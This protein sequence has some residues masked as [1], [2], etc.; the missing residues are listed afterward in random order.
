MPT[1]KKWIRASLLTLVAILVVLEIV[2]LR[3]S[4]IEEE[5]TAPKKIDP[6]ALFQDH[7]PTVVPGVPKNRIPEYSVENFHYVS[8]QNSEKLWRIQAN[9]A[10]LYNPE[11]MMHARTVTAYLYDPDGKA[12]I[13]TGLEARYF[14][15]KKDLEMYGNVKTVFPDGFEVYSE[16]LRYRPDEKRVEIPTS[17][18]VN[19]V[20][21][22]TNEQKFHFKSYGL[23]FFMG[24]SLIYLL[25]EVTVTLEKKAVPKDTKDSAPGVP[26]LTHIESDHCVID[27]AKNLAQFT[28]YPSRPLASRYVHITQ[29]TLFARSRRATLN[30]GD[31]KNVLNYLIA[32]DDVFIKDKGEE[33]SLRYATGGQANFD[34]QRDLIILT[35]YPQIYQDH[36]TVTGDVILMHRDTDLI[37]I[38]HS[39]AFS[40]G[41]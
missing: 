6:E 14:L 27:R 1:R 28:M 20:G 22:E 36:D 7:A 41:S 11:K 16:Y 31:F 29:P 5:S 18:F 33:K 26:D 37:E 4:R 25:K 19:G 35:Q 30:Y 13:V 12:T 2:V 21:Q 39:N 24:E 34:T 10:R 15:N 40:Q 23:H 17:Y 9:T 32:Y 38:E 8:V 3:P